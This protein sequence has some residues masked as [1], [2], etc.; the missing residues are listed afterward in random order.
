MS[1]AVREATLDDAPALGA[2]Q[3]AAL[4]SGYSEFLDSTASLPG[5]AQQVAWWRA[6]LGTPGAL[7]A[8]VGED[9]G[10]AVGL[11]AV[12]SGALRW[13]CV[14]PE[15]WGR[16]VASALL[17]VAEAELAPGA[18]LDVPAANA[19]ARGLFEGRGWVLDADLGWPENRVAPEVRYR[20]AAPG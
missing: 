16:G 11:V 20:L 2:L 9:D 14:M 10:S 5:V 6:E 1:L 7:R 8:W 19:R 13:V 17:A 3:T 18:V 12:G 4:L 15:Q